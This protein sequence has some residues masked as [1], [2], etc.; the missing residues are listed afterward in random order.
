MVCH[1]Q[2]DDGSERL[3]LPLWWGSGHVEEDVGPQKEEDDADEGEEEAAREEA[4]GAEPPRHQPR[5]L[6]GALRKL[7]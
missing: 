7:M 2:R 1:T 3:Q 6:S 5:N 4:K